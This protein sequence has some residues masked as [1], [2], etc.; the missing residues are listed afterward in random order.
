LHVS[1]RPLLVI[2]ALV[3]LFHIA[4]SWVA[5]SGAAQTAGFE[6]RTGSPEEHGINAAKL[7][8]LRDRLAST[9]KS[10]L[11]IRD[12]T[13]VY[14]WYSPDHGPE[15][16]H[17]TASMAKALVAG[18]SAGI[19]ISDGHVT[20]D[21]SAAQ[22]V[23]AW[24]SDGQ[25]RLIKVRHLGS[26]TSGLEDAEA[27]GLSHDKLSGWKGDFWKRLQP[28]RD[29]FTLARDSTP[30]ISNPGERF[31]YSNPG[32][33]MLTYVVTTAISKGPHADIRSLLRERVMK[34]IGVTDREWSVGYNT[35]FNV[36][37][38]ALI[39]SWGG[40]SYTARAVA[41]VGRLMLRKGDWDGRRL[42]SAD[43]VSQI[44]EDAGTPGHGG[45]GWWS[46]R[47]GKYPSLPRDAF[48]GSGAGHQVVFVVPS[49]QL[50]AVR[51]GAVL[52]DRMEHHDAL[53]AEL[54]TPLME[55]IDNT[56]AGERRQAPYPPS[57]HIQA[58]QW[59]PQAEIVRH[60][61]GS[62]NFPITWADDDRLYT[63][64]GDGWGFEPKLTQ[65]L[66]LGLAAISGSPP[67]IFGQNLRSPSLEQLGDGSAGRKASGLLMVDGVLYL[68]ARNAGNS[69]LAW[70][71]DHGRTW[72]WSGWTF[73]VSFGAP[74]F[75]N[76]G[77]NYDGAR[78]QFVYIYSHDSDS[79]YEPGDAMVLARVPKNRLADRSAYEFFERLDGRRPRW[80]ADVSQRGAVFT[81]PGNCYRSGITYN[82]GLRR[83]LWSQTLPEA[84][85]RY[86]GGFGIYDGP[87]PW[88]PWTVAFFTDRWDVGPGESSSFPAK[89]M[90]ADGRT[91]HLV[92]SGN[93]AF[94]V[95][96]A[97]LVSTGRSGP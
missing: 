58:V 29:P 56:S 85:A 24:R 75:L 43:A 92:F 53:N 82:R 49:K 12:D 87:E 89:W 40:G 6:W 73:D 48:W 71:R 69:Q 52:N 45:I 59:A 19:A 60:A 22:Y 67:R 62:D 57:G 33:A 21:D 64:Y 93:D 74:T 83:Y 7:T 88:G 2:G 55:A 94:S 20:L 96:R 39:G 44:S 26:H 3:T 97:E 77:R 4:Y 42:L 17:Y 34:P 76:F 54:L 8:A 18:L 38:L 1:R 95:R 66:S 23:N 65:K 41:R 91:V 72:T 32:I 47:E 28:P 86:V 15:K 5:P 61:S 25:K 16:L 35:T 68:L 9:T 50:I 80:T 27:D 70:S 10:L 31:S 36:D 51:N 63:A 37:G 84:D 81:F 30:V 46:N 13:V 90:S 79:A 14:E 78:D 11:I